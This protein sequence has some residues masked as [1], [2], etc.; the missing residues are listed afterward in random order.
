MHEHMGT[1]RSALHL[2]S[3]SAFS[4]IHGTIPEKTNKQW[5]RGVENIHFLKKCWEFLGFLQISG[6]CG[7]FEEK[8]NAGNRQTIASYNS[9]Q[10]SWKRIKNL[11]LAT[12][13]GMNQVFPENIINYYSS[14]G[15]SQQPGWVL[16]LHRVLTL[17]VMDTT[18]GQHLVLLVVSMFSHD[19]FIISD[20]VNVNEKQKYIS[21]VVV[22]NYKY[23]CMCHCKLQVLSACVV[24]NFIYS[25][26]IA[27]CKEISSKQFTFLLWL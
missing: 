2:D 1:T 17:M 5:N 22:V 3:T 7:Y 25:I 26:A 19:F 27:T 13:C 9:N 18:L 12:T 11:M 8:W 23:L 6:L 14:I 16:H 20:I 24:L 15:Y 10:L 21:V 4:S